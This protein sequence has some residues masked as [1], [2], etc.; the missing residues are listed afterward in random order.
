MCLISKIVLKLDN[1]RKLY[2]S[3]AIVDNI[4]IEVGKGEVIGFGGL[5]GAGKTTT[6]KMIVRLLR[7][8]SGKIYILNK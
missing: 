3:L 6:L 4:N 5:N 7:S 1:I 8:T 2:G